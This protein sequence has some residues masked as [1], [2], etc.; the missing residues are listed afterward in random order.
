V[1][2]KIRRDILDI[3]P[4]M[5]SLTATERGS[6]VPRRR[7]AKRLCTV[8]L[9]FL[10][11]TAPMG[12]A[13]G[14][15]AAERGTASATIDALPVTDRGDDA[16]E[17]GER[18][19][20]SPKVVND[21]DVAA[22]VRTLITV[23]GDTVVRG[24]LAVEAGG[25]QWYGREFTA[26]D[27]GDYEITVRAQ[28]RDRDGWRTTDRRTRTITVDSAAEV[29]AR[30][31]A[32]PVTDLGDGDGTFEPGERLVVSPKVVNDGDVAA[33][34]RTLITV[35]GDAVVRGPLAVEAGDVQ[36]YGREFTATGAGDYE[37]TVRVEVRDGGTWE[38]TDRRTRT[39]TVD[40]AARASARIDALPVTDR[41]DGDG[42]F[43][44]GERLVVS[45]KV[46]ND[47]DVA[48]DV[49]TVISLDGDAV[50]RGPL[51][52]EAG[53]VQW[54]GREFTAT[55][56]GDHEI[57]VRVEVRDGGTW[58][59]TD[60]ADRTVTVAGD[61]ADDGT[62]DAG[63]ETGDAPTQARGE[64]AVY[65]WGYAWAVVNDEAAAS[66]FFETAAEEEIT[67]V[68]LAAGV[69]R[70]TPDEELARFIGDAHA[71]G[72]T[73]E[74]LVPGTRVQ[75]VWDAEGVA[76]EVVSYNEDRAESARF[77]GI[78][79]DVEPAGADLDRF[80]SAYESMLDRLPSVSGGSE[81]VA[82]QGLTVSASV[83]PYWSY[84]H[85]ER[86]KAVVSHP[87][88]DYVSLMAYSETE[89]GVRRQ[90]RSIMTGTD[91]P[92]LVAVETQEFTRPV[93]FS[94]YSH[95]ERGPDSVE[96]LLDSIAEDPPVAGYSGGALHYYASAVSAWHALD[97][98]R[99]STT[100]V[101]PG[102][103]LSVTASILFDD[104]F[105]RSSHRSD[106]VVLV[107]GNGETYRAETTIEPP[108][109]RE[110]APTLTVSIPETA[111]SGQYAVTVL[112]LDTTYEGSDREAVGARADPVEIGRV[113]AG[114]ITVER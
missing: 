56:A 30:I 29:S 69:V 34:V 62:S 39:V 81:T 88:M 20:V 65:V 31:D 66:R 44:P 24:P 17:P 86:A 60:T 3:I 97:D 28:V 90:V 5:T 112:L 51:A 106:V 15:V 41:G 87:T 4:I 67:T 53:D 113:D 110:V 37:I 63:D 91:T 104:Y 35:N 55:D 89:R 50:V 19:V 11:V 61:E 32:L 111:P 48:A 10:L 1:E 96:S 93:G 36:W 75:G 83:G 80:L 8:A 98:V 18:L 73:V 7:R 100:S 77:D 64:R 102:E 99:L 42:T 108:S 21:G 23:N 26:T 71:R 72:L 109:R 2:R 79:F 84:T 82:S 27:A 95:Y 22:D 78:H 105:A 76:A 92:Y 57:S 107:E 103:S 70:S 13:V 12:S 59:T 43:E 74:A 25:V 54:Y 52:V 14:A 58:R 68:Y 101:R 38:V 85:P 114:T 94:T 16:F 46:V 33:D 40:S 9:L 47:G 45:P 49:R 6:R